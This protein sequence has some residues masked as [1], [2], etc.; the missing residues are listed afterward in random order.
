MASRSRRTVSSFNLSFLDIMFCGFGA[1]VLLVLLIDTNV[2]TNRIERVEDQRFEFMKQELLTSQMRN[3]SDHLQTQTNT[4]TR[5]LQSLVNNHS[6]LSDDNKSLASAISSP[7]IVTQ[8]DA[9]LRALQEELKKLES[10][11]QVLEDQ[12][13]DQKLAG[14]Q[15]RPF[16]GQGDRQYLT[17]LK[18]GGK[19]ILILIDS[20]A[21]MLERKI[22]DIIRLKVLDET[23]RRSAPKWQRTITTVEWLLANL[24]RSSSVQL[25]HF[26]ATT[27]TLDDETKA[28]WHPISDKETIDGMV[29]NLH[30][31]APANGTNLESAFL[32]AKTLVPRPDNIILLTDGL[33]TRAKRAGS[34][35][36]I[37]GKERVKLFERA[38][39]QLP[40]EVPVNTILFPVEGDPLAALL[41]WQLALESGGSFL[42][43]A[44]DWP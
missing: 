2:I 13:A 3:K 1:V 4:L 20:S 9:E 27:T 14:Q 24:P 8:L 41:F 33:P 7:D 22:V 21:S 32:Q 17:G 25:Y 39:Q 10:D 38:S 35:K 28:T 31:I 42:T 11:K 15:A 16:I 5:E 26:N 36:T 37:S 40:A 29:K 43:P 44:Q 34:K 30:A 12:Q 23:T 19:R 18:L 6:S